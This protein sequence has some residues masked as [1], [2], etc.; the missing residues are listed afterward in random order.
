MLIRPGYFGEKTKE[1]AIAPAVISSWCT[2][3]KAWHQLSQVLQEK[4]FILGADYCGEKLVELSVIC[5][6]FQV[7]LHSTKPGISYQALR[8]GMTAETGYMYCCENARTASVLLERVHINLIYMHLQSNYPAQSLAPG[9]ISTT[10]NDI[11]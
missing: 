8:E 2:L 3:N 9:P 4:V 11:N 6:L 7:C 5:G 10:R 1:L